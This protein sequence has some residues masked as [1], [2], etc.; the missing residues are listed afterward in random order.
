V[1]RL[2]AFAS[3]DMDF[4]ERIGI[5]TELQ[6]IVANY[7]HCD[8]YNG[9]R[10][11]ELG[12]YFQR[13]LRAP[14]TLNSGMLIPA[15]FFFKRTPSLALHPHLDERS[16]PFVCVRFQL[17]PAMLM[18]ASGLEGTYTERAKRQAQAAAAAADKRA[19]AEAEQAA[20]RQQAQ[21]KWVRSLANPKTIDDHFPGYT[22]RVVRQMVSEL[23]TSLMRSER[24]PDLAR[25]RNRKRQ[26]HPQELRELQR[27][28]EKGGAATEGLTSVSAVHMLTW[29]RS[30]C[31]K[32]PR[33]RKSNT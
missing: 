33:R 6:R 16:V 8:S 15:T 29:R 12:Q 7:G 17:R 30:V 21:E 13:R 3:H 14:I 18:C 23:I 31:G 1:T 25:E 4:Y 27:E 24:R 2:D 28:G 20:E 9:P 32:A 26:R 22:D 11:K 5:P 19:Q 10:A